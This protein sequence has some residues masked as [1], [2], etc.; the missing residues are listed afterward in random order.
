MFLLSITYPLPLVSNG[1]E[2]T[3]LTELWVALGLCILELT[4]FQLEA[5]KFPFSS[6]FVHSLS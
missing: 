2:D 6:S 5:V 4:I 3:Y 1:R